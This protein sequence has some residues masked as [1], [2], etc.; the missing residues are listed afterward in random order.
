MSIV[1]QTYCQILRL[2]IRLDSLKKDNGT[3]IS[4]MHCLR[5]YYIQNCYFRMKTYTIQSIK[6][7]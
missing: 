7:E 3:K 1:C 2:I 6:R 5:V 4:T